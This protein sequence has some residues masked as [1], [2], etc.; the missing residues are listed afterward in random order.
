MHA[1]HIA[2]LPPE[3]DVLAATDECPIQAIKH[4]TRVLYGTQFH[5][6]QYDDEH[7]D[8][9]TILRNFFTIAGV[10]DSQ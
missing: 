1:W 10:R 8:G 5:P 4:K 2:K 9:K 7:T 3:F 6:E